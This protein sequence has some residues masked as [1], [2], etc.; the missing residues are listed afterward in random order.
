MFAPSGLLLPLSVAVMS[1]GEAALAGEPVHYTIAGPSVANI[2]RGADGQ[3]NIH[4]Q[5]SRYWLTQNYHLDPKFVPRLVTTTTNWSWDGDEKYSVVVTIDELGGP[6][7]HRVA[8]FSDPGSSGNVPA[9]SNYYVTKQPP[10]CTA[11]GLFYVRSLETGQL[12]FTSTTN[13]RLT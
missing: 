13:R 5:E 4:A 9:G 10:C 2:E 6:Q 11:T 7:P 8:Q 12:L 3:Y 1:I